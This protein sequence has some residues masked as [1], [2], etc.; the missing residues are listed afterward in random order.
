MR[1]IESMLKIDIA[2]SI[3]SKM[4][5]TIRSL[6]VRCCKR[7]H[8]HTNCFHSFANRSIQFQLANRLGD[9]IKSILDASQLAKY[10]ITMNNI[11]NSNKR[12]T[13]TANET[14]WNG[15]EFTI[16]HLCKQCIFHLFLHSIFFINFIFLY[17]SIFAWW[18]R[19]NELRY[20]LRDAC[21]VNENETNACMTFFFIDF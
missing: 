4:V 5:A 16:N 1:K 18:N 11:C 21:S 10:T 8:P 6:R 20:F 13:K 17:R 14:E 2:D 3:D 15:K 9:L 12:E 7:I 19:H